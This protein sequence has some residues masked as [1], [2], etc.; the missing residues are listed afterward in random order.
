MN[1]LCSHGVFFGVVS[2]G[3]LKLIMD[4]SAAFFLLHL[5]ADFLTF[6]LSFDVITHQVG[7]R[8]P[9]FC[10]PKV[11]AVVTVWVLYLADRPWLIFPRVL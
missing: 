10:F 9:L 2:L 3:F 8:K 11:G 7:S 5:L 6:A 1:W 4:R